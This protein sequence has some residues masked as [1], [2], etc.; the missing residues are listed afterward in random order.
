MKFK[1][2][3]QGKKQEKGQIEKI[4]GKVVEL[5]SHNFAIQQSITTLDLHTLKAEEINDANRKLGHDSVKISKFAREADTVSEIVYRVANLFLSNL[6]SD[7]NNPT[8]ESMKFKNPAIYARS[9]TEGYP[10]TDLLQFL[11]RIE[12]REIECPISPIRQSMIQDACKLFYRIEK[13]GEYYSVGSSKKINE[14]NGEKAFFAIGG[15]EPLSIANNIVVPFAF[16]MLRAALGEEKISLDPKH[17]VSTDKY[18]ISMYEIEDVYAMFDF[19]K[20]GVALSET[21]TN[22]GDVVTNPMIIEIFNTKVQEFK[23]LLGTNALS[24]LSSI[25]SLAEADFSDLIGACTDST[26][27]I[28]IKKEP[29]EVILC[30]ENLNYARVFWNQI[31]EE[32]EVSPFT[33]YADISNLQPSQSLD[34]T[35]LNSTDST[36]VKEDF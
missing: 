18:P 30:Q 26:L 6:D 1:I 19:R 7:F 32:D 5:A 34:S 33:H 11:K 35:D 22:D 15:G 20:Q 8:K 21:M 10:P 36:Y 12:D 3:K 25:K 14:E 17:V 13:G 23:D 16:F 29:L 28:N 27:A 31:K 24:S 2:K 4:S 9:F